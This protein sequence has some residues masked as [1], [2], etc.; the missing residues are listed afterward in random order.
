V[1]PQSYEMA[2]KRL[3]NVEKKLKRNE[4]L[5]QEYDRIIKDYV[6]NGY[7]EAG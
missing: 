6:S 3:V 7:K 2:F 1:L 5:A 4:P